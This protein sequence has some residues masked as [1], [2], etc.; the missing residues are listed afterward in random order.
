LNN[1][2]ISLEAK[3]KILQKT[4]AKLSNLDKITAIEVKQII[5]K[6][7]KVVPLWTTILIHFSQEENIIT[8]E[9]TDFLNN[10]DNAN[11]L[12]ETKV[13]KDIS[14][15]ITA[16]AF[17]R[18]LIT[19]DKLSIDS[20][21]L[22]MKSIPYWYE[23]LELDNFGKE[24][25]LV[26]IDNHVL[27]PSPLVFNKLKE[28]FS[29]L[30]ILLL[31]KS[32]ESLIK[33]W[34]QFPFETDDYCSLLKS[35]VLT[36]DKKQLI[37]EKIGDDIIIAN[38][39]LLEIISALVANN[40][41]FNVSQKIIEAI[42]LKSSLKYLDKISIFEKRIYKLT[43]DII[44]SFLKILD[45]PYSNIGNGSYRYTLPLN[46]TAEKLVS[47]LELKRYISSKKIK[48]NQIIIYMPRKSQ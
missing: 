5:L 37:C 30:H 23:D 32:S 22:L 16:D 8:I 6:Y 39:E 42:L 33:N 45:K 1:E 19:N 24:K 21:S 34:E 29:P 7:S 36:P 11:S 38:S 43:N 20:Y 17:M 2:D 41:S 27:R 10:Q 47:A 14:D 15:K 31:E 13:D 46:E 26:L 4:G 40:D 48:D 35:N 3:E 18:A 28:N 12:C 9:M 25:I 44:T